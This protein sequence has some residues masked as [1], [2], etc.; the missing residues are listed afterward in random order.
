M[1]WAAPSSGAMVLVKARTT[2]TA[3]SDT[4]TTF[5]SVFTSTYKNY[6]VIIDDIGGS[7]GGGGSTLQYQFR[8]GTT[9]QT[10]YVGNT[11][12]VS[13]AGTVTNINAA[14]ATSAGLSQIYVGDASL[15]QCTV[16]G[17][18]VTNRY[19]QIAQYGWTSALEGSLNG[20]FAASTAR[21]YD[22]FILSASSGTIT[23]AAT[24]YGL[25]AS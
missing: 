24:V 8:Y 22:G 9:T 14:T 2:F 3:V 11:N 12:Q 13:K 16:S 7:V 25:V 10:S 4:S 17:V 1:K 18:A 23:G 19:A 6:I 5:D 20:G 15:I 21:N